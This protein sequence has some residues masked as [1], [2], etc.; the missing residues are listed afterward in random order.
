MEKII[1]FHKANLIS[2][3]GHDGFNKINRALTGLLKV[4]DVGLE[5]SQ[6]AS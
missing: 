3:Y 1:L 2:T 5:K 4:M 6:Y